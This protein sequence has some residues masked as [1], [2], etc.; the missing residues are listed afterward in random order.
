MFT[1]TDINDSY[2][3]KMISDI[4]ENYN[5]LIYVMRKNFN[6]DLEKG[7]NE[8]NFPLKNDLDVLFNY[9]T[10]H[11]VSEMRVKE[12]VKNVRKV[13][14]T[15]IGGESMTT[16][17]TEG[18]LKG[19]RVGYL[20]DVCVNLMKVSEGKSITAHELAALVDLSGQTII[21]DIQRGVINAD[22]LGNVWGISGEEAEKYIDLKGNLPYQKD[23]SYN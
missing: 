20:I 3:S 22:K 16:Q 10:K 5:N 21:N 11:D 4:K 2:Y 18:D 13:L 17:N 14:T 8:E 15:S 1:I 12:A 9:L 19:N 6:P 7:F 23:D